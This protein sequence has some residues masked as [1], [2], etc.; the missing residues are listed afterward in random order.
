[1]PR[2]LCRQTGKCFVGAW[3]FTLSGTLALSQ[4]APPARSCESLV[5]LTLPGTTITM[6]QTVGA[7]EFKVPGLDSG[8][9]KGPNGKAGPEGPGGPA[10]GNSF[11]PTVDA[12]TLPAFCRVAA[13]LRP[14]SDSNIEIEVWLPLKG[15]NGNYLGV[16]SGGWAGHIIYSGNPIG[17]TDGLRAG[18]ASANTDAGHEG[19][20]G[21]FIPGH[22]EKLIDYGYRAN[23]E[24][25]VKAKAIIAAFYGAGPKYSVFVGCSLGSTQALTEANRFPADYDG[26]VAGA[27]MTPISVFNAVQMW[28]GWLVYKD[29]SKS[30]PREKFTMIHEAALKACAGPVG[31][32]QGFI[33][34]PDRC[35][36]DPAALLCKGADRTDCLTAPQVE[37][38]HQI[39]AGPVDPSTNKSFFPGPAVGGELQ[40]SGY[41]QSEPFSPALQLYKYAVHQDPNWDWKTMDF[42]KDIALG[43]KVLDPILNVDSDLRPFFDHGGKLLM[44]IGWTDYH[45][46]LQTIGY[47]KAVLRDSGGSKVATSVRL[48]NIPGM[49]HCSGGMG[50]DSF[51]KVASIVQWVE[52]GK[53]PEQLVASKIV[54]GK[55]VR[56]SPLCAYPKVAKYK[57]AGDMDDAASFVCAEQ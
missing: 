29:P 39:Y 40:L 3:L 34:E 54:G 10:G 57:G 32:K 17:L 47:Y 43:H 2:V 19:S 22:P 4:A 38:M 23:H 35:H 48:F 11:S 46:P 6:A 26:V 31:L 33:E 41:A 50:C 12:T 27:P 20:G 16:G 45:N 8:A 36:F 30:I 37:L 14:T 5:K 28:P 44:Y 13:T 25:T 7:G 53:A 51:D 56:T 21:E 24:M 42:F 15:W 18:Y 49:D 9:P 52:T 1:M 55:V